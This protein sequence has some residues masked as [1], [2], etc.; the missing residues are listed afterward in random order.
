MIGLVMAVRLIPVLPTHPHRFDIV[1]VLLS[2]IGLFLIVFGLQEGQTQDWQAWVWVLVAAGAGFMTAFV[3]WQSVNR[4]EP[5]IPLAIFG[6]RDFSL[7]NVG[8]AVIGFASTA[9]ILPLMFYAQSGVRADPDPV[10]SAHRADGDR[11]W[12]VGTIR[13]PDRRPVAPRHIIGFGFSALAVALLWLSVEMSP[14]TPVWRL[15]IPLTG[16]G[17]GLAFIFA[18]LSATAT[19]NLHRDWPGPVRGLQHHP[20]S[21]FGAR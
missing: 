10:G 3:Y 18:P 20:A 11:E 8:I 17:A 2:G 7:A 19:R 6:D 1:G 14:S 5:L 9:M 13:R 4:G 21:R 12:G 16:V 15:L